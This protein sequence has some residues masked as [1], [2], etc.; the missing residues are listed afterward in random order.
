MKVKKEEKIIRM[1][2][3]ENTGKKVKPFA[4]LFDLG[5]RFTP[6]VY[7]AP[8]LFVT[9][10][11]LIYPFINTFFYSLLAWDGFGIKKF[12]GFAN[13]IDLF[14][15][16]KFWSS[17]N[18]NMIYILMYSLVPTMIGLIIASLIGR[19]DLKGVRVY[20]TIF[21]MPQVIA[22]VA[23]GIIFS[24][25]YSP[26][27]GVLNQILNWLGLDHLQRAWL[28][29]EVTAP[30]A[31]GLI[32]VWLTIGFAVIIFIAGIQK[33]EESIYEAAKI[34]G[35]NSVQVFF[36]ITL[37]ELRYEIVVVIVVTLIRSL[38][39]NIFGIVS[40]T[41]GGAYN[42]RPISLYAYQL[43]FV[44]HNVG[45]ASTVVVILVVIILLLSKITKAIGERG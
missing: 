22:S 44:Q 7:L 24:W 34:D 31:I 27:F 30:I 25:I 40:S 6:F 32:G 35:A 45:Y 1:T 28:G 23:V 21:F 36:N 9:T 41:T 43:S 19:T 16:P 4:P 18:A 29:N 20:Q 39:T 5:G 11:F 33:T 14:Q 42:T 37:P 38:S 12:I 15:D 17:F 2:M 26:Q 3:E 8:S 13:Y 10:V